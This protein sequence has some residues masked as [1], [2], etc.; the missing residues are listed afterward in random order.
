[1]SRPGTGVS[2]RREVRGDGLELKQAKRPF[3]TTLCYDE[4]LS[5]A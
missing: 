2:E 1:M 5:M 4:T 3:A